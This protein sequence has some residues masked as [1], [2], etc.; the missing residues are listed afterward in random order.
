MDTLQ[1]AGTAIEN[2]YF[3]LRKRL[4][5]RCPSTLPWLSAGATTRT[6]RRITL[7]IQ[8]T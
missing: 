7:A 1:S 4:A 5:L 6:A 8:I 2:P 3:W